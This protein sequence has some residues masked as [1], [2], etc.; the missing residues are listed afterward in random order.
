MRLKGWGGE[1]ANPQI[2]NGYLQIAI[3]F[4]DALYKMRIPGEARQVFDCIIRK[5]WG[6]KKREDY[7]PL[8]QFCADTG[9]KKPNIIRARE[10]LV[11]M[12][13][14]VIEKDNEDWVKYRINKD[15]DTWK[16][17]SKKIT[18]KKIVIEKDNESI[19]KKDNANETIVNENEGFDESD[20]LSKKITEHEIEEKALSK[21]ITSV[22]EKDN[23]SL[24]K[25]IPSID[26]TSK[27]TYSKEI[28]VPLPERCFEPEIYELNELLISQILKNHPTSRLSKPSELAKARKRWVIEIER[29]IRLDNRA[30][31]EIREMILW[32]TEDRFW[33]GNIL[34]A[35]KLR[36]KWDTLK[37]QKERI[38]GKIQS[39]TSKFNQNLVAIA[40]F[41][42]DETTGI[43]GF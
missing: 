21:K 8:S 34:S 9:L 27:E 31:P 15:F 24:S 5:T 25:K 6:W 12:N 39:G 16:P 14:I 17:L 32:A 23:A 30:P 7:I 42:P 43:N 33:S 38:R 20:S 40:S 1:V 18:T 19:I 4:F 35:G 11:K 28:I 36:E 10:I 2:E 29:L 41:D 13:L 26:T 37:A 3:S 22:I